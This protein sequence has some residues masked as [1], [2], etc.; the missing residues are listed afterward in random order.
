MPP[1]GRHFHFVGIC[2]TA[3][4]AVAA[5]MKDRGFI[6]TG[7]D[8]AVY[9]PMASFL[10]GRGIEVLRGF[11]AENIPKSAEMV[12]I[13]NV[14][15]RGNAEC[16]EVLN[17]RLPYT[18][19]PE[20]LKHHFLAGKRNYVVTGTHGKTT[21]TSLLAWLFENAGCN[22][23]FMIG[24]ITNNFRQG[25]RFTS[26][27]FVVIEGDEYD[28]AFFD[29]RSKFVHYLPEVVIVNNLEF[30]HADIFKSL[31]D[32]QLSFNRLFRLVPRN[33]LVLI[34]GDDENAMAAT[35]ENRPEMWLACPAPLVTVGLGEQNEMRLGDLTFEEGGTSFR[36]DGAHFFV[37]MDGEFNARNAAMAICAARFAGLKDEEI[38]E[39]LRS[40]LGIARRQQVRGVTSGGV[41]IIDDFGHHPTAI[42]ETSEALRHR[43]VKT[44]AKLWAV[45]EPRSN[46][47]RRKIFQRELAASLALADGVLV[48]AIPDAQKVPEGDRLDLDQL[49]DDVRSNGGIPCFIEPDATAIVARLTPLVRAGDVVAVFSNGGFD[50]IHEKLLAM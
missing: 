11:R 14:I 22:P 2:G 27:E 15:S 32:I 30:D 17:R 18:S 35:R 45:F 36:L 37:P 29:K 46:T 10:R 39:G 38:R 33:G 26:S 9:E 19:L 8:Q 43:H 34:N 23:S 6:I 28:T 3:M 31:T 13:G 4:G 44:G 41:T 24:G 47:T 48:A 49:A 12:V 20:L 5:A 50:G 40:F 25:G 21:T 42:R 7:S 16:E 1:G